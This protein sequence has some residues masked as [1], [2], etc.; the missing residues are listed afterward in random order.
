[1][2]TD[3]ALHRPAAVAVALAHA[4][5][6]RGIHY[7]WLMVALTFLFNVCAAGAMSS[8]SFMTRGRPAGWVLLVTS[9][10]RTLRGERSAAP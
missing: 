4:L 7:G 3:I 1:M 10:S 9:A 6:R 8:W 5:D 2:G